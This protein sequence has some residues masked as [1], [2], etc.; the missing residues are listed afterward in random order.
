M[1][2]EYDRL[3]RDYGY[4][5]TVFSPLGA[6]LLTTKYLN[7]IPADSR[8]ALQGYEWLRKKFTDSEALAKV[9]ALG[10][11]A[12]E[13]GISLP[14][15]ALNWV[16]K[17]PNVSS[18]ITGASRVEQ[19]H[20]NMKALEAASKLTPDVMTEIEKILGTWKKDLND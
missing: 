20:D 18:A 13:I 4:G 16:L 10:S 8:G 15:L 6:G 3:F 1:E 9:R 17:N 7:G 19:V 12:G 14:H 11:L 5:A 2:K